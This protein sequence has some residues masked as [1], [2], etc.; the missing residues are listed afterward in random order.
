MSTGLNDVNTSARIYAQNGDIV[1][2]TPVDGEV[3][4]ALPNGIGMTRK[5]NAG[6]NVIKTPASGIV[7][8][9]MNGN[10]VKLKL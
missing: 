6:R 3:M 10:V 2:E 1:V 4:I 5:V 7:L 8:V 9:R